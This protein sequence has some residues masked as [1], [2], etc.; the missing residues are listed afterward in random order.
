MLQQFTRLATFV[1][2]AN[3]VLSFQFM[4]LLLGLK[5]IL[6]IAG[7]TPWYIASSHMFFHLVAFLSLEVKR[8]FCFQVVFL[9]TVLVNEVHF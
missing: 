4:L 2:S 1:P 3:P 6:P 8:T 7:V 5:P 9:L